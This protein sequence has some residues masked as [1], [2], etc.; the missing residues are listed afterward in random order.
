MSV[1]SSKYYS[2]SRIKIHALQNSF[3]S[4]RET[5]VFLHGNASSSIF[6]KQIME[7]LIEDFNVIA[8]D[9]RGYGKT[10]DKLIDATKGYSDQ[11]EDVI[12][13]L[14]EIG[15]DKFHVAGH[16]MGGG[17]VYDLLIN[18]SPRIRTA[19]LVNPVSPYGFGGT[20]GKEGIPCNDDFAGTGAGSV[21]PEFAE[22]IKAKD[23]TEENP[24]ASPRVVMN[25]FYWKPPFKASNENEL[26]EGLL[27]E[28]IGDKK[29][30]GDSVES[31][32]WPF[33][34]PGKF[35]PVNAAS[36]KYN[37]NLAQKLIQIA[38]KPR[39]LWVR[40]SD[41]L[42]VSNNS[43]FDIA[44]LGKMGLIPEFPGE[45]NYPPQ[46]MVDQTRFVLQEYDNEGGLSKEVLI[47]DTGH[48]PFI[49]KP[50]VFIA[51]FKTFVK[52]AS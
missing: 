30:P 4:G 3:K 11:S 45:E 50:E 18:H 2:T 46:P 14:D 19:T 36:P 22:R 5:I 10:E 31:K 21:N 32:N 37:Q 17:V 39:I 48:T 49:E 28:K 34:G 6:W 9:L 15:V 7:F 24:N 20:K 38:V 8:P 51:I 44:V 42:I 40:G 33:F 47:N 16:S 52:E 1:V 27:E 25:A 29:Y 13:L 35:G 26:L 41:D 23:R 12:G 43:L